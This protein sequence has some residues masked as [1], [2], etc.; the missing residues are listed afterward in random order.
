MN[1]H[2][3]DTPIN[4]NAPL[5]ASFLFAS[6]VKFNTLKLYLFA[7]SRSPSPS[8]LS[9]RPTKSIASH[10]LL[11]VQMVLLWINDMISHGYNHVFT[12]MY[13]F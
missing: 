7:R 11:F 9:P 13:L 10:E 6:H 3:N 8:A 2:T 5:V 4:V 12:I 1:E